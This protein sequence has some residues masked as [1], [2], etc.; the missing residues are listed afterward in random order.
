MSVRVFANR[1]QLDVQIANSSSLISW[2]AIDN[3]LARPVAVHLVPISDPRATE[4]IARCET[5]ASNA[6]RGTIAILDVISSDVIVDESS[7]QAPQPMA[8][9]ITEWASEP[10]LKDVFTQ[11]HEPLEPTAAIALARSLAL[12]V[13]NAHNLGI[14]HNRI[15]PNNVFVTNDGL[16]RLGGFGIDHVMYGTDDFSDVVAL[17]YLLCASATGTWP[18]RPIE[19]FAAL[20]PSI[21]VTQLFP[22]DLRSELPSVIDDVFHDTVTGAIT[23]ARDFA[24]ALSAPSQRSGV[25]RGVRDGAL[26]ARG[27]L[28]HAL[29]KFAKASQSISTPSRKR[30]VLIA[31]IAVSLFG[32]AGLQIM[33]QPIGQKEVPK[34]IEPLP[35][36]SIVIT[37]ESDGPAEPIKIVGATDYDPYGD[38]TENPELATLAIDEDATSEW[39]TVLYR[40]D[41]MAGKSGVG[42][43]LDLGA[44]A[45]FNTLGILTG[46]G[47]HSFKIFAV[48]Q[49]T[50]D[51]ANLKPI[52]TKENVTGQV[53]IELSETVTSAFVLIWITDVPI[54]SGG[55][56]QGGIAN[57]EVGLK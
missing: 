44:Q 26:A 51:V 3:L 42:L 34:T 53:D 48:D 55:S 22:S 21:D 17:A 25:A 46:Q 14:T 5:A 33:S 32:W 56:Y 36:A 28:A 57:V 43:L 1:Y 15:R 31:G 2:R 29:P 52:A 6:D 27:E 38:N 50:A 18:G 54:A 35:S 24:A 30:T 10:S 13:A 7:P 9:I 23:T 16:G 19:G 49:A 39:R 41:N 37:R 4:L 12:V 11:T 8:G 20:P 47:E 40:T 45:K